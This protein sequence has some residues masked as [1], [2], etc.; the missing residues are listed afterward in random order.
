MPS[1]PE[2]FSNMPSNPSLQPEDRS[3]HFG[4]P[5]VSPPASHIGRPRVAQL[6]AGS[7]LVASPHLPHLCFESLDTL[8]R[9]S[10]PPFPIQSKAQELAF[11]DPP[12]SALGG[13]HLQSQMLLDPALYRSQSSVP[14]PPDCL[15]RCC[16]HPHIGRTYAPSAPVPYRA[17]PDRCWPAG[18]KADRLAASPPRSLPPTRPPSRPAAG[19]SRST[20]TPACPGSLA[21]SGPSGCRD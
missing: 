12:R 10:D 5:E 17:H 3:A 9:Y 15:R 1:N 19:T 20:A 2:A 21:R 6:L 13:I 8:R 14:P 11:P 18:V 7:T 16:S 4:Q